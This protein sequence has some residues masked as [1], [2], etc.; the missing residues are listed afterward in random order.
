MKK[1]GEI[2]EEYIL[3]IIYLCI[4]GF[5]FWYTWKYILYLIL[6]VVSLWFFYELVFKRIIKR[7]VRWRRIS[8]TIQCPQCKVVGRSV[9]KARQS[10]V[11]PSSDMSPIRDDRRW[12]KCRNCGTEFYWRLKQYQFSSSLDEEIV[13]ILKKGEG[14]GVLG[15]FWSYEPDDSGWGD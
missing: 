8:R 3:P 1:I 11:M 14:V 2:L 5:V 10:F 7:T 13:E 4:V 12:Y 9:I 15:F 6:I